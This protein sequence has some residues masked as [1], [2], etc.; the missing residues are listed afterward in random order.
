MTSAQRYRFWLIG[1][2]VA[3]GLLYLLRGMLLPFVAGMAVAYFLDPLADRLERSG[4]SRLAATTVITAAF[5]LLLVLLLIVLVP[6]IEDQVLAFAHKVPGYIDTLNERLQPLLNEAKKRLSPRDI[7]KLRS[8]AGEYAGT[9]ASWAL[10][11]VRG[12]LTGSLAVVNVLSLV[13][14]TPVVTFYLLRDWDKMVAKVDSW[15]PRDHA[16][17]IRAQMGEINRTLSGFIRG[18]ATVCLALGTLYG[19]GLSLVG[20]DL[21]LVIGMGSGFLSFIPYLGSITGFV[22]GMG[23]ALAQGPDWHLPAMVAGVFAV[24][25]VAEGNFLT[26][27]LVGD[28]V[29]LHPVWIM[30]ALLAGG[31]LFGFLGILL[32]VPVSAVIGVLVRFALKH[33]LQSPIYHG[34]GAP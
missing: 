4:L 9:V 8:S 10:G 11:A 30:F 2:A 17:T 32:A 19:V 3:V 20:L 15:L 23:L 7:E 1:L 34:N 13:F 22:T 27:K 31:S 33:Y 26:P 18:Q 21:G 14:I 5:F 16:D 6:I 25:Q 12:V 28:K 24:G 29:G